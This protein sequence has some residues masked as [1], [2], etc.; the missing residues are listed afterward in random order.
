MDTMTF[1]HSESED[2]ITECIKSLIEYKFATCGE[3]VLS[4]NE[5][6]TRT[7]ES[8]NSIMK[9][10]RKYGYTQYRLPG[11]GECDILGWAQGKDDSD[12]WIDSFLFS[13]FANNIIANKLILEV[14]RKYYETD[15]SSSI[16]EQYMNNALFCI[17]LYL[18]LLNSRQ[19]L[20]KKSTVGDIKSI[21]K[22]CAVFYILE[23]FKQTEKTAQYEEILSMVSLNRDNLSIVSGGDPRLL[24][25]FFSKITNK[26]YS[27]LEIADYTNT[28]DI[29]KIIMSTS[30]NK[31]TDF[32]AISLPLMPTGAH[33][34]ERYFPVLESLIFK[35]AGAIVL[36]AVI[37]GVGD[38]AKA[39]TE[40]GIQW[41]YYDNRVKVTTS[42]IS[43]TKI[44]DD[45]NAI[46]Y[47]KGF[48][49]PGTIMFI[50]RVTSSFKGFSGGTRKIRRRQNRTLKN[51][52]GGK[53]KNLT[54]KIGG[55]F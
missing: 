46:L 30:I 13:L 10:L 49:K 37:T 32:F 53:R 27:S 22:W 52:A 25:Y 16:S 54:R 40:C 44:R 41:R 12:C 15:Y 17:T 8:T 18:N 28:D 23:Y 11:V 36:E 47:Y 26:F 19:A 14:D 3:A 33:A 21:I 24:A 42:S 1:G 45:L 34:K 43:K 39:Y 55:W 51:V 9:L 7:L 6:N 50:Y 2:Y 4:N 31:T 48:T 5:I 20:L 29:R 35:G 38:H